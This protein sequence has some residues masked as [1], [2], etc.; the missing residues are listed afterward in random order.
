MTPF[1]DTLF[2][3]HLQYTLA[4][5]V[6]YVNPEPSSFGIRIIQLALINLTV[7][8]PYASLL[9]MSILWLVPM[10]LRHQKI[11]FKIVEIS[12]AWASVEV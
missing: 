8:N 2:F 10:R 5:D 9:L 6:P 7:V 11:L 4:F 12:N 1:L 3:S